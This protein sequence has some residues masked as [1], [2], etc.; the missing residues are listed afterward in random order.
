MPALATLE[1][2]TRARL[3]LAGFERRFCATRHGLIHAFEGPG[4]G[5]LGR[6]VCV[7]GL[8]SSASSF[9]RVLLDLEPH[10]E[11]LLAL[12]LPGHGSS[13]TPRGRLHSRLLVE[14]VEE[15]L[16]AATESPAL[17]VGN[18]LGGGLALRFA[19]DHPDRVRGLVL[20][21]PAG[22]A[23]THA[24]STQILD[25]FEM[26]SLQDGQ[27]FFKKLYHRPL[28]LERV[29][30]WDL[31]RH[32]RRPH[33]RQLVDELRDAPSFRPSELS[34]LVPP[35][36]RGWGASDDLMPPEAREYFEAHSPAHVQSQRWV[37]V[38]HSPHVETPRRFT[39]A[40]LTFARRLD[41]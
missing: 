25:H 26:A 16:F 14:S 9:G 22:A 7:H 5:E 1:A 20:S 34:A 10:F 15:A 19:L 41:D 23:L 6:V 12:D 21:S 13:P 32:V 39:D 2:A 18:S 40:V 17:L 35:A 30:A 29:F 24:A 37:E 31:V 27:R 8:A 11:R 36:L 38:G 28:P 4:S 3:W 33:L